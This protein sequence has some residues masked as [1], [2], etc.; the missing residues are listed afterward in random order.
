MDCSGCVGK[1]LQ[2]GK[3][4]SRETVMMVWVKVEVVETGWVW[5]YKLKAELTR[6]ADGM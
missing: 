2:K 4:G 5:C 6:F 1:R 3:G